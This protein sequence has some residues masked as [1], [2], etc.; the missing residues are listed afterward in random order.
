M[1]AC[2]NCWCEDQVRPHE[3][4]GE[5]KERGEGKE[6]RGDETRKKEEEEEEEGETQGPS[7]CWWPLWSSVA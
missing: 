2:I 7:D 4:E 6:M 1:L 3:A 5:E